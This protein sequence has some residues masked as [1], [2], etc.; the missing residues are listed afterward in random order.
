MGCW[1]NRIEDNFPQ[2]SPCDNCLFYKSKIKNKRL[3]DSNRN[4]N[5]KVKVLT[6]IC[7]KNQNIYRTYIDQACTYYSKSQIQN[8]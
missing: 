1:R 7:D 3:K 6:Y 8:E 2:A 5:N 4:S